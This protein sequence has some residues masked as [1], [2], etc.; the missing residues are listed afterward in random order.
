MSAFR[1]TAAAIALLF[2]QAGSHA[3]QPVLTGLQPVVNQLQEVVETCRADC[4]KC[5]VDASQRSFQDSLQDDI[6]RTLR[7]SESPLI[8]FATPMM[9]KISRP[10]LDRLAVTS[11]QGALEGLYVSGAVEPRSSLWR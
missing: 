2:A 10:H 1:A 3:I 9:R 6:A 4:S 7:W 5:L 11:P 8:S